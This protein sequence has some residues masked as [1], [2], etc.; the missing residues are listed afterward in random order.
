MIIHIG[1]II[2]PFANRHRNGNGIVISENVHLWNHSNKILQSNQTTEWKSLINTQYVHKL[3]IV[4][5]LF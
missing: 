3:S 4:P 1:Q 5:N 2:G